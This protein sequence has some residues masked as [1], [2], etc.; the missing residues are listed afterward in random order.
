MSRKLEPVDLFR[1]EWITNVV[2]TSSGRFCAYN[3]KKVNPS[4]DGYSYSVCVKDFD[5]GTLTPY[6]QGIFEDKVA[7][8]N[9]QDVLIL[10]KRGKDK[11][12]QLYMLPIAGGE[13]KPLLK[14]K[15]GVQSARFSPDGRYVAAMVKLKEGENIEFEDRYA[16]EANPKTPLEPYE[17]KR[18][19]YK[20][21]GV[22]IWDQA[23]SEIALI[24]ANSGEVL[25]HTTPPFFFHD[26]SFSHDGTILVATG[27][28]SMD[29]RNF[30]DSLFLIE[31]ATGKIHTLVDEKLALYSPNFS[32]DGEWVAAYGH[33]MA[34]Q[35]AT[36]TELYLVHVP[37]G[38]HRKIDLKEFPFSLSADGMSDMRSHEKIPGP[39]FAPDGSHVLV[40]YSA[41]GAVGLAVVDVN[42]KVEVLVGGDQEIFTYDY[43]SERGVIV[44]AATNYQSP[45]DLFAF[46][47]ASGVTTPI[48]HLNEWL[49]DCDLATTA[50]YF[51]RSKDGL[52]L[53]GW[54]MKPSG[55]AS[56][57]A[58]FPV[59][60]QVHG[61]PHAMF[62]NS[63][64]FEFQLLAAAG[65]AVVYGNPRGSSGYGQDFVKACCHDYGGGDYRDVMK[66]LDAALAQDSQLDSER[67]GVTGGSYGGFMTNWIVGHT[68]RFKAAVTQR[69]ISNW[70]SF[71]GVSDIGYFFTEWEHHFSLDKGWTDPS[72]LWQISPL[73]YAKEVK[74]PLLIMHG[75]EDLRCP[76]E[77][78]EQF[79]V[80]L[81]MLGKTVSF[82]RFPKAN[83][84][85][86]RNGPPE[87]RVARYQKMIDWFQ[88]FV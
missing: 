45:N 11:D 24:E 54:V 35:G 8:I 44:Y 39:L 63:F 43:S 71:Y 18:L 12:H 36:Q 67:I 80:A 81:A 82:W 70:I 29:D 85:L 7:A 4:S 50:S 5:R 34:F 42:G 9:E 75:E 47:M 19:H 86:S 65:Y 61:G 23:F 83:H 49:D 1:F 40:Q 53:Q 21:D 57:S 10:S 28:K 51:T 76:I 3:V 41:K 31:A 64:S 78:A 48:T 88:K 20:Q 59:I 30:F 56:P 33:D 62:S 2:I 17:V 66:I 38:L 87:L 73:R 60:L 52:E 58:K 26:F 46:S 13:A 14:I 68:D 84:D 22:G 32:Q 77:Q 74:T 15:G 27:K 79:Y 37:D 16:A 25:W 72:Y 69:S 55:S 6:T